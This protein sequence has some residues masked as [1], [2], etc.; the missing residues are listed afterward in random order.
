M[1][2]SFVC[3][4][5]EETGAGEV[6]DGGRCNGKISWYWL[7]LTLGTSGWDNR[8]NDNEEKFVHDLQAGGACP[9][10]HGLVNNNESAKGKNRIHT[11][12]NTKEKVQVMMLRWGFVVK[13][14]AD[15]QTKTKRA[16]SSA[17]SLLTDWSY[18]Q[19]C[20]CCFLYS[21]WDETKSMPWPTEAKNLR[22]SSRTLSY[23]N[24]VTICVHF[25][26]TH[27]TFGRSRLGSFRS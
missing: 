4:R 10:R 17:Q 2:I 18:T 27:C 20:C 25:N 26:L 6:A 1:R 12:A 9:H 23:Y 21:A 15:S 16:P 5:N 3:L 22:S 7:W 13:I 11:P 14:L 24:I 8:E 19:N